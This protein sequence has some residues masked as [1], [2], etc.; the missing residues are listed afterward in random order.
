MTP[1][2]P[3]TAP[4]TTRNRTAE[5][6]RA[7]APSLSFADILKGEQRDA[8]SKRKGERTRD[9][10]LLAAVRALESRGYLA[11]RVRD[12][13]DGARVSPAA[14]YQYFENCREI[15]IE[16]LTRFLHS[17]FKSARSTG[18]PRPPFEAIY[19]GNL[20]WVTSARANAGLVRCLLQLGDEVPEFKALHEQLNHEW[21]LHV[22]HGLHRRFP[23][24]RREEPALLLT[25]HALGGMMDEIARKV[26]VAREEHL[27]PL[28]DAIAPTDEALAEF[29]SVIWFRALFGSEPTGTRMRAS[30]DLLRLG[31]GAPNTRVSRK[32]AR[33]RS[34]KLD[35]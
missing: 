10:L 7:T 11:L 2:R 1:R 33:R 20:A 31:R 27:Q 32:P 17:T 34:Q 35:P 19:A 22:A 15:T 8:G 26:L 29:L 21:F 6:P 12:I 24:A 9:R 3:S 25:V 30:R 28:V 16:V 18:A 14:F 13:C 4:A 5:P 23:N